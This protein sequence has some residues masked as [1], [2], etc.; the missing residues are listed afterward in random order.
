MQMQGVSTPLDELA[1]EAGWLRRLARSLVYDAAGAEDLVQ[2]AYV[3]AAEHP[4][5]RGRSVRPWLF[6]VLVNRRRTRHRSAVRRSARERAVASLGAAPATPA[7]LVGRLELHRLLAGLVLELSPAAREVV[8]LHYVE[9]LSSTEIGN[10]LGVAAG[11]V[12]WRLKQA[13]DELRDRLEH[14]EP[15]RAWIPALAAFAGPGNAAGTAVPWLVLAA[16]ALV[17]ASAWLL[18]WTRPSHAVRPTPASERRRAGLAS[19][20]H[21]ESARAELGT[22]V[23]SAL[24]PL[25]PGDMRVEGRVVDE[26]GRAVQGAEVTLD[27]EYERDTAP[28]PQTRSSAG[29]AF[30]FDADA[31]CFPNLFATKDNL[32]GRILFIHPHHEA[33]VI[34]LRPKVSLVVQVV[35]DATGTP[36]PNAALSAYAFGGALERETARSDDSGR[37]VLQVAVG[38]WKPTTIQLGARAAEHVPGTLNV[39]SHDGRFDDAP[40]ERTIRLARGSAIRGQ[41][42]GVDG[43]A[44]TDAALRVVSAQPTDSP[45][46]AMMVMMM[47]PLPA[48]ERVDAAGRF[49]LTVRRAGRYQLAVESTSLVAWSRAELIV[50]V[51]P[52]GRTDLVIHLV[53]APVSGVSGVVVDAAGTPVAGARIS[54]LSSM[55]APLAPVVTDEHGRFATSARRPKLELVAR[56]GDQAS[57]STPVELHR[58]GIERVT[59]RLGPSGIAGVVVDPQGAPVPGAQIW[60]NDCC[61]ADRVVVR[62]TRAIADDAGRFAFDVPRGDFVL[63]VRRTAEDD[64]LDEDDRHV[65]GGN[66]DVRLVVP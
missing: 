1:A 64:F 21:A 11:T 31:S 37:A 24:P 33:S 18:V 7:E 14:R 29:G 2:D 46:D 43:A 39:E 13:V 3:L 41:V 8:L 22:P 63:S 17:L 26:R 38:G 40:I 12:R 52:E 30:A 56:L 9:G 45:A 44:V 20:E 57:E 59:L 25:R 48:G 61:G 65:A 5:A 53:P 19:L 27:C 15:N 4:P 51:G 60:L 35:D 23:R 36:L 55:M 10:R 28:R 6:R 42:V 54:S 49:A 32:A 58:G 16:I 66:H 47:G 34:T 50:D 62:G